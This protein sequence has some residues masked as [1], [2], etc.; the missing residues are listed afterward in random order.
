M[1]INLKE[2]T[3]HWA[4]GKT[5]NYDKFPKTYTSYADVNKALLPV[6]ADAK[7]VDCYN[8]VKYTA[9]FEDGEKYEGRLDISTR[10]DNPEICDNV[11]G[12]AINSYLNCILKEEN[13]HY[14]LDEE[15]K[16]S[17]T[18]FL[19]TYDLGIN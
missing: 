9:I 12:K 17:V 18:K 4:E 8:K 11:I 14:K 1:K 19:T 16:K 10:E 7:E 5:S 3:I 15:G 13:I 6:L 2:I